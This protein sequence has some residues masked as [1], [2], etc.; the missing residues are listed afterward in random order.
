M[1]YPRL[2]TS[3]LSVARAVAA[4]LPHPDATLTLCF[5][6]DGLAAS[7]R[8]RGE[9]RQALPLDTPVSHEV[10]ESLNHPMANTALNELV[11]C[12]FTHLAERMRNEWITELVLADQARTRETVAAQTPFLKQLKNQAKEPTID[13]RQCLLPSDQEVA[14]AI[15]GALATDE[16]MRLQ[17]FLQQLDMLTQERQQEGLPRHPQRLHETNAHDRLATAHR[18]LA[19]VV[20]PLSRHGFPRLAMRLINEYAMSLHIL[21]DASLYGSAPKQPQLADILARRYRQHS[22]DNAVN[23]H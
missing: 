10:L 17:V 23:S 20:D 22:V 7:R 16:A 4:L 5:A 8:Q 2:F 13:Y 9:A 21:S 1:E 3:D 12:G 15:A 14:E 6:L 11:T 18:T 19:P